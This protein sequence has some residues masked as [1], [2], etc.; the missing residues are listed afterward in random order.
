MF[1]F[2]S[3]ETVQQLLA[4]F[5]GAMPLEGLDFS[6]V[7]KGSSAEVGGALLVDPRLMMQS[8][9]PSSAKMLVE[10]LLVGVWFKL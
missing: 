6:C 1:V 5:L 7:H 4:L 3:S 10:N 2:F 9:V 8:A